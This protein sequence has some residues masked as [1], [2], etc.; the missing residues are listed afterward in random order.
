MFEDTEFRLVHNM[1]LI[2]EL[3]NKKKIVESL[4]GALRTVRF[5]LNDFSK[6][7]VYEQFKTIYR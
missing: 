7:C 1:G 4:K 3:N 6:N 5:R 2:G